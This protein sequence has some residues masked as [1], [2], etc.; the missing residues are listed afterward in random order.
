[1]TKESKR[2]I[3]EEVGVWK[4]VVLPSLVSEYHPKYMFKADECGL[5]FSLFSDKT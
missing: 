5:I 2:V 4:T 1:M 3:E